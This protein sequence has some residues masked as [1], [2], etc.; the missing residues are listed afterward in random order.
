MPGVKLHWQVEE[1]NR[2][3]IGDLVS[4]TLLGLRD[5]TNTDV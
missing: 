2:R 3:V 1:V 4:S 5:S